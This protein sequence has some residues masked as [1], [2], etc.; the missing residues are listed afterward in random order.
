[1]NSFRDPS[2][3]LRIGPTRAPDHAEDAEPVDHAEDAEPVEQAE[4]VEPTNMSEFVRRDR[5]AR[6]PKINA[7][8]TRAQK[9]REYFRDRE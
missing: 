7:R 8:A 9:A 3:A 4:D 5:E 2:K 6:L 1:V